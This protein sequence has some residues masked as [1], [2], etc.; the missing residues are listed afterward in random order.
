MKIIALAGLVLL[1]AGGVWAADEHLAVLN[2]G[3]DVYSNVTV[4][5]IS[6]THL[7]FTHAQGMGSVKLK[8]LSPELQQRFHYNA[9]KAGEAEAKQH[10]A[11]ARFGVEFRAKAASNAAVKTSMEDGLPT[12]EVPAPVTDNGGDIVVPKLY[13]RSF[14]GQRPPQIIVDQWITS[15]P[16]V[17]G[18]FVLV[19]FWA[20][21]CG[22]C[23]RA[24]PHLNALQAKFK[25]KLVVI[26]LSDESPEA[27]R[28]LT[29]PRIEYAVGTDTQARTMTAVGVEGIPHA[30]LMDPQG[31]VRFEGM[32]DY[33]SEDGLKHLIEKYSK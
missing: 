7:S 27:I 31:I 4:T 26:G 2:V 25:D 33:L 32:P 20:T 11:S 10:E 16:D 13:A 19:D 18:K 23:K 6:A 22:P 8:N 28:Q 9:A 30:M 15:S 17:E 12:V 1:A 24:I 3:S 29:S 21:W 5:A 14:R